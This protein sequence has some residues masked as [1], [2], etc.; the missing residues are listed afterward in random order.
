M[1]RPRGNAP[2]APVIAVDGPAASGKGTVAQRTAAA[3]GFHYLDSGKLYRAAALL[4]QRQGICSADADALAALTALLSDADDAA[5]A[6]H[7]LLQDAAL[8]SPATGQYA[9]VLAAEARVRALLLPLQKAMRRPPGLV[10]D[11][12]DMGTVVFP[13]ATVRVFLTADLPVRARRRRQQL[14]QRGVCATMEAVCADLSQRDRQDETRT[15]APLKPAAGALTVDSTHQ[16][17]DA[18]VQTILRAY[19]DAVSNPSRAEPPL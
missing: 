19:R 4:A 8:I 15:A 13:D 14:A 18:V 16:P 12:R 5:A 9:S 10:A 6:L 3:L 7:P 11:G 1:T 2:P 17:I